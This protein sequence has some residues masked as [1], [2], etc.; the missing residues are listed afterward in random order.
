M[1]RAT[2]KRS[3]RVLS[4]HIARRDM[5]GNRVEM[6]NAGSSTRRTPCDRDARASARTQF[7]HRIPDPARNCSLGAGPVPVCHPVP[8]TRL[9][10]G[11]DFPVRAT[12][13]SLLNQ[14]VFDNVKR[15]RALSQDNET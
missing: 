12:K 9:S 15:K 11:P 1:P 3:L 7:I 4:Y 8:F 6:K 2:P 14:I 13:S 10:P 5:L